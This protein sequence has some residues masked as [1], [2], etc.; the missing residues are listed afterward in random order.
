MFR[1]WSE[2]RKVGEH[3]IVLSARGTHASYAD[4]DSL[5]WYEAASSCT[6]VERCD[7]PIWPTW[8]AGGLL[9]VGEPGALLGPTAVRDALAYAG[10]WGGGGHFPRSRPAPQ[11]PSHQRGFTADGFQ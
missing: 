3:P 4:H 1:P 7:D 9:N 5:A 2:L 8:E 6:G 11:G 10:R